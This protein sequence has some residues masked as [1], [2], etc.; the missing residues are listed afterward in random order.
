MR[1]TQILGRVKE[2]RNAKATVQDTLLSDQISKNMEEISL[3]ASPSSLSRTAHSRS[4][5]LPRAKQPSFAI[6]YHRAV[7]RSGRAAANA[8]REGIKCKKVQEA[9]P[10]SSSERGKRGH[11]VQESAGSKTA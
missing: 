8:A 10:H 4:D 5:R 1:A 6:T 3:T 2:H 11:K 7:C 9:K